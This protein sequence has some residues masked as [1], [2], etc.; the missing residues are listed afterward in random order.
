MGPNSAASPDFGWRNWDGESLPYPYDDT[1]FS[2]SSTYQNSF[3]W[4]NN[5]AMNSA[6]NFG[7][8][9]IKLVW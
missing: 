1:L 7:I 2:R 6:P 5:I 8:I 4:Y 3:Y 9:R